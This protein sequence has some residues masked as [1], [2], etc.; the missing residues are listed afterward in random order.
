EMEPELSPAPAA[1]VLHR[2]MPQLVERLAGNPLVV[3]R[4][5]D[6]RVELP[7]ERL[8]EAG[9]VPVLGMC[10]AGS[11]GVEG[12]VRELVDPLSDG[13]SLALALE[14]LTP[15]PVDDLALPVHHVVVLEQVLADL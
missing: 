2:A 15:H 14:N 1:A 13:F 12:R 8:G 10:P 6:L 9:E 7:V 3:L 11:V 5:R 4:R